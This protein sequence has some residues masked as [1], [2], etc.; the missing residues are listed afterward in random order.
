MNI[1]WQQYRRVLI[2][3][4]LFIFAFCLTVYFTTGR[5]WKAAVVL[6]LV[7]QLGSLAS[8]ALGARMKRPRPK[9]SDDLPLQRRR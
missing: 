8:A 9:Q 2:P 1:M 5:Q 4:Q 3:T 7:M 6:F